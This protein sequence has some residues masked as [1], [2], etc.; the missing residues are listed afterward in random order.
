MG[1]KKKIRTDLRKNRNVRTRE[2]DFT[3]QFEE[4]GFEKDDTVQ[5][6]RISGKGELARRRT[7]AGAEVTEDDAGLSIQL[8][9]DPSVC[10]LGRVLRVQGLVSTVRAEP[11]DDGETDDLEI[12]KCATRGLLKTLSTDQRHVL[13]AG[14]R[15]WLRPLS[16]DEGVIERVEPRRGVLS[17]TSRGRQH[18]I[19][20]NVDQLVIVGSPAEPYLKPNL[21]DRYLVTAEK[22]RITPLIVINKIDLVDPADVQPL[23]GVYSQMGYQVLLTS[24]ITGQGIERL[25]AALAGRESVFSGQSG[26]GK[27]SLLNS[28]DDGLGLRVQSISSEIDMQVLQQLAN[29][30]DGALVARDAVE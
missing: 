18:I 11:K 30:S 25:R 19:V 17:R 12:Y 26:V 9:V 6:E 5:S 14:D 27:S 7:L 21:I 24:S 1:K 15:V 10:R 20:A 2:T 8:S 28:V 23:V 29:R 22:A 3:R 4:H 16:G 13:A